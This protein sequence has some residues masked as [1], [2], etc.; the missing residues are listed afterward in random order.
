MFTFEEF[1]IMHNPRP[2]YRHMRRFCEK[3]WNDLPPEKQEIIYR[4]I[5]NK[6]AKNQFVDYNPYYAIQKNANP[7]R[8]TF[9][10]SFADYYARYHTTEARD[11]WHIANPTGEKVIYEKG[12]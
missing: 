4:A 5:E 6:K 10:L 7:P 2:E 12:G 1:W 8:R 9:Q 11:G 3:I